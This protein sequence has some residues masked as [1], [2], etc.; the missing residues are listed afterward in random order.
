MILLWLKLNNILKREI[1]GWKSLVAR[2]NGL[3]EDFKKG[4]YLSLL[5]FLTVP[6]YKILIFFKKVNKYIISYPNGQKILSLTILTMGKDKKNKKALL[7][8]VNAGGKSFALEGQFGCNQ[9][10]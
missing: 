9:S 2:G 7:L 4:Q 6:I 1:I 3:G 5:C 8:R 10:S